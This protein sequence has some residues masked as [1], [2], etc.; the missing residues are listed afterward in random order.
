M[1][2]H[3]EFLPCVEGVMESDSSRGLVCDE[4]FGLP[5]SSSSGSQQIH[6]YSS[7]ATSLQ[8]RCT[9]CDTVF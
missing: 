6:E 7:S 1:S 5:S 2:G 4:S 9:G 8:R 3:G